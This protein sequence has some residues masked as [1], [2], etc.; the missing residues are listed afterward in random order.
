MEPI[1]RLL[2]V[3]LLTGLPISVGCEP[4]KPDVKVVPPKPSTP[5]GE[6]QAAD[7]DAP[8]AKREVSAE[9]V[10]RE[11]REAFDATSQYAQQQAAELHRKLQQQ[12]DE[13]DPEIERL[14]AQGKELTEQARPEWNRRMAQ[15][16]EKRQATQRKLDAWKKASPDAWQALKG[17]AAEAWTDLKQSYDEA[18]SHF[19]KA[20]A[21]QDADARD[22]APPQ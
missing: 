18:A 5:A 4:A 15:L 22:E 14:K 21:S 20:E 13:L 3:V 11:A 1:K 7:L 2:Y 10:E 19:R 6:P 9:E 8:Q 12:I 17:G 16:E